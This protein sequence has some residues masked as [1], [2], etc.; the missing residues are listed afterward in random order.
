[1]SIKDNI[2]SIKKKIAEHARASGRDPSDITLMGVT[3][4]VDINRIKEACRNGLTDV[5][6]NYAQEFRDKYN[7]LGDLNNNINWHFI[8]ALQKNK[9][10]YLVGKVILI[11]SVDRLKI[12]EEISKRFAKEGISASVLIEVNN[13]EEETKEGVMIDDVE[14]LLTEINKLENID[15]KGFMTMAPYYDDPEDA[16]PLFRELRNL[17]DSLC[18]R[19][20]GLSHL[21]M[22]MSNDYHIAVEEGSTIVRIGS[23]IFG[24][25]VYT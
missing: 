24:E 22:G 12:A 18:R 4:T 21:S 13:G 17:K 15:V 9:V 23:S 20:T 14:R 3:K 1:M 5:G 19:Y 25:R 6:E 2:V 10:K 11:H 16:R 8:G 7:E